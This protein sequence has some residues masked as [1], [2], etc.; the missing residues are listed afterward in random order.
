MNVNCLTRL[1]LHSSIVDGKT[2]WSL[3]NM[4]VQDFS[5]KAL[6]KIKPTSQIDY[7]NVSF[8]IL[9]APF[10]SL[11]SVFPHSLSL[12]IEKK[13]RKKNSMQ[14]RDDRVSKY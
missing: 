3:A 4:N 8:I 1:I 13:N 12:Y 10:W 11:H 14:V 5:H 2:T 6:Y 7:F 9:S